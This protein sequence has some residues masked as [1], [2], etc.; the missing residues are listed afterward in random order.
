[1][2]LPWS[3]QRATKWRRARPVS[4]SCPRPGHQ[5]S[6]SR[7]SH[8]SKLEQKQQQKPCRSR[9]MTFRSSSTSVHWAIGFIS[10]FFFFTIGAVFPC[11]PLSAL[12]L[13]PAP[14]T[15]GE[16]R[17]DSPPSLPSSISSM[18]RSCE[19]LERGETGS[20]SSTST[21]Q[22]HPQHSQPTRRDETQLGEAA[23]VQGWSNWLEPPAWSGHRRGF[24][25]PGRRRLEP[26]RRFPQARNLR[27]REA[28][29]PMRVSR[30]RSGG[31][32]MDRPL[33]CSLS[34]EDVV[35]RGGQ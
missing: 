31:C 9:S 35:E 27:R 6:S 22:P 11:T 8:A 24:E 28:D 19:P 23:V 13:A 21:T 17:P 25:A 32:P 29:C 4:A 5:A 18:Q 30:P 2:Y 3:H 12:L 33:H 7:L 20:S 34:W 10:T 1:M 16:A 26:T 15:T 14:T